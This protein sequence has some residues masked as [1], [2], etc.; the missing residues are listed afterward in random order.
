[1]NVILDPLRDLLATIARWLPSLVGALLILLIGYLVSKAVDGLVR[2]ALRKVGFDR[3]IHRGTGGSYI[4]RVIPSP[5]NLVGSALFWLL[6]LGTISIAVTV[7]GVPALTNFV[8][9][10]YSYVPNIVADILIFLVAGAVSTVAAALVTRLMGETP[11]GKLVATVVPALTMLLAVFM[12][13]NQLQIARDIVNITYTALIGSVALGMALAFG[14]GGRQ[15]AAKL[16][17]QAYESGMH[18]ARQARQ[19]AHV[20][21]EK[22]VDAVRS[23]DER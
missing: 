9:A 12:I 14:L 22:V 23:D 20:A 2:R 6:W 11:T 8:Y 21:K 16:L 4:E 5:S 13:L 15:V 1:M 3:L 18:A 17:E 19:D 7:L 10:I